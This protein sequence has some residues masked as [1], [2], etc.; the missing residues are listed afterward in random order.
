MTR[1]LTW[2][3]E[4]LMPVP[5]SRADVF[6]TEAVGIVEKRMLMKMLTAI[7]GY[8]EEEMSNEFKGKFYF[9]LF[10]IPFH[11]HSEIV[12][13]FSFLFYFFYW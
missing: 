9:F 2:L 4:K 11:S 1:V 12:D 13:F 5:C 6:S 3:D 10:S 8:N 7:V